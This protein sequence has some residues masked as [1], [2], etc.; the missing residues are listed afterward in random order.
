M[1]TAIYREFVNARHEYG[2]MVADVINTNLFLLADL[3]T[4][5]PFDH[6]SIQLDDDEDLLI[7]RIRYEELRCTMDFNSSS[8]EYFTYYRKNNYEFVHLTSN[9]VNYDDTTQLITDL[10]NLLTRSH[11]SK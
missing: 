4:H 10:T 9:S 1:K 11:L 8:I 7:L 3:I 6:V 2:T 5:L